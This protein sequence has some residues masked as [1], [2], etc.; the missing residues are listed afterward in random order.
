VHFFTMIWTQIINIKE[1]PGMYWR[2][3]GLMA[4]IIL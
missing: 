2:S 1:A 3:I 4:Q